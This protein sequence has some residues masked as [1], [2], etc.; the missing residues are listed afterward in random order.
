VRIKEILDTAKERSFLK[1]H[2]TKAVRVAE[3][4]LPFVQPRLHDIGARSH[5]A[6]SPVLTVSF[7]NLQG[8]YVQGL[9]LEECA[10]LLNTDVNNKEIMNSIF[11]TALAIKE[12]IYGNR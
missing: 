4:V 11:E 12:R 2:D 3:A 5:G 7:P 8:E 6:S 10:T 9:T 1:H